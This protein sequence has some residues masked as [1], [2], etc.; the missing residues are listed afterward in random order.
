MRSAIDLVPGPDDL[1]GLGWRAVEVGRAGEPAGA[2][3]VGG[4]VGPDFPGPEEVADTASSAH[5]VRRRQLVHGLAVRFTSDGA[6]GRGAD[7]LDR[8]SFAECLARALADDLAA[9]TGGPEVLEV[10]VAEGGPPHRVSFTGVSGDEV[11][12][13]HL[14]IVVLVAGPVVSLLWF[15]DAPAPFP[16]RE[17]QHVVGRLTARLGPGRP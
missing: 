14:D 13:V 11:L 4:C 1:P 15:G 5:Y 12:T 6:A 3:E 7:C 10:V 2:G 16:E 8:V 17:R 9:D